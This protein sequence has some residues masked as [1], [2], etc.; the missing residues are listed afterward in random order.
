MTKPPQS[1]PEEQ[2]SR[3]WLFAVSLIGKLGF[4]IALPIVAFALGGSALDKTLQTSP[5]FLLGGVLLASIITTFWIVQRTRTLR[6][7]YM[8]LFDS[9]P[10]GQKHI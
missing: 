9:P 7:K 2:K 8:K 3:V 6:D 5:V 1:L 10:M 4:M